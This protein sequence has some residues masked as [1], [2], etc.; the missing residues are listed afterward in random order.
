MNR[1][2]FLQTGMATLSVAATAR[3]KGAGSETSA[4]APEA[5]RIDTNVSLFQWPGRRLP[6]D[7]TASLLRELEQHGVTEAW[8]GSF[9]GILQRDLAGVN[10]RLAEACAASGGRLRAFGSVNPTLPGWEDDVRRCQEV[11]RMPGIRLHPNYHGYDLRDGRFRELLARATQRRLLVQI[12]CLIE[13][14]RTQNPLLSVPDVDLAPLA[15]ALT[16]TP[17]ARVLLLN[18]GKVVETAAFARLVRLPGVFV[19]TARIETVGGVGRVLRRLP[20]GRV[21][22]GSHAPFFIH[23]SAVIKLFESQLTAEELH[24]LVNANPQA[25]LA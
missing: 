25:L 10:G 22:F 21:V 17:G 19:D 12:V 18:S 23:T 11:H 7:D 15:D 16:A 20:A 4:A 1:R 8:A 6:H 2:E 13:D 5:R 3:A 9:E 24:A 14:T